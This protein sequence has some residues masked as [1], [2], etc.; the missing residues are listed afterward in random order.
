V[1]P[2]WARPSSPGDDL[3]HR[4]TARRRV[5]LRRRGRRTRQE[6]TCSWRCRAASSEHGARLRAD[7]RPPG[8]RLRVGSVR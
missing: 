6:T 1:V 4:Q 3:P 5:G 2:A 7:G 8:V